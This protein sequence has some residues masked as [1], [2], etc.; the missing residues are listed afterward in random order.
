[1]AKV[2]SSYFL[3]ELQHATLE[4]KSFDGFEKGYNEVK[5]GAEDL[6]GS[7]VYYYQ[8]TTED[9]KFTRKMVLIK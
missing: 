8:L 4:V 2:I 3:C 9:S 7:G 5:I 1:M 6:D